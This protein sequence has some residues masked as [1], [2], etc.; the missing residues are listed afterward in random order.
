MTGRSHARRGATAALLALVLAGCGGDDG[1]EK[2]VPSSA[3]APSA[4]AFPQPKRGEALA[5]I[6]ADLPPE[7]LVLAPS[8]SVLEPGERNRFGFGLFDASRRQITEAEVVLYFAPA[9]GGEVSGPYPARYE[10][11]AVAPQF[12][13]EGTLSDPDSATS[14]YVSEVPFDKPGRYEVLG[15]TKVD[16]RLVAAT[17]V[18]PP[19]EVAADSPVPDVGDAAPDI[20]TPTVASAGGAIE[21]I[22]TRV[23]PAPELH[24]TDFADVVGEKP[25]ALLFATPA[26]CMSAVCGPVVDVALQVRAERDGDDVEFIHQ[27]IYEDNE[28]EAGFLPQVR[29]FGL[30]TEPWLFTIDRDGRIAARIE[31]AFSAAELDEAIE[32]AVR[33]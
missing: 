3:P 12:Q 27:E 31:G 17:S 14:V 22:D 33:G 30:P 9:G 18:G 32:A 29:A 15:V 7:S 19:M 13:S 16:D 6:R 25:V 28:L 11:L 24:D 2:P 21:E 10:S 1:G 23:P 20:S 5:D 26:L 4:E 8:V